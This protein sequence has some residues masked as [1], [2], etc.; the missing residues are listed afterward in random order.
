MKEQTLLID[1]SNTLTKFTLADAD[2]KLCG[3]RR[4]LPTARLAPPSVKRLL[5]DWSFE[6][7]ILGSVVPTGQDVLQQALSEHP[8]HVVC[9]AD[10]PKLLRL[11]EQP[12]CVGADRLAN[13]AAV[14]LHYP[15]PCLAVDLGTACTL[16]AVVMQEGTPT[17]LGGAIAPGLQA[18]S[19]ALSQRANLLPKLSWDQL[20]PAAAGSSL[21]GR[22]TVAAMQ[23]G[24]VRGFD[25]MLRALVRGIEE[26]LG[27]KVYVV[28]TGGDATR[29]GALPD[30]ADVHDADLTLKGLFALWR[31][32]IC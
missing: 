30:W 24:I 23:A 3:E 18:L 26:E 9:G 25:G 21:L 10:C 27:G 31:H 19:Q 29:G 28:V 5:A 13:A 7:V 14:A 11:Y 20:A 8:I 16:D 1:N 6:Q 32:L 15:L 2:G 12:S 4:C 17:L 22:S